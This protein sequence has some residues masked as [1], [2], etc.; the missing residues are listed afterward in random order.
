M[1]WSRC[2]H[3]LVGFGDLLLEGG[4]GRVL[5]ILLVDREQLWKRER[6]RE[7]LSSSSELGRQG[8][9][10]GEKEWR[11]MCCVVVGLNV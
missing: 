11:V 6:N 4:D 9:G 3:S 8:E 10:K 2:L 7:L 5:A 1:K